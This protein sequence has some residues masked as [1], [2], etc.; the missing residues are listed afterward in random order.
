MNP[1]GILILGSTIWVLIDAQT[2]GIKR[3]QIKGFFGMGPWGWFIACLLIW[4]I[5]FPAYIA[6]RPEFKR[7]NG[8]S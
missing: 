2:I 6:K 7:I 1:L 8:K 4:I 3:G 5:A